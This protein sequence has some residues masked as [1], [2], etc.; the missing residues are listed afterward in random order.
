MRPAHREAVLPYRGGHSGPLFSPNSPASP[1][2]STSSTRSTISIQ[3]LQHIHHLHVTIAVRTSNDRSSST[4]LTISTSN[5]ERVNL[6]RSLRHQDCL[7]RV[8]PPASLLLS[9]RAISPGPTTSADRPLLLCRS[10]LVDGRGSGI[11][12]DHNDSSRSNCHNDSCV[13]PKSKV[14][15]AGL[16]GE[17]TLRDGSGEST[18]RDARDGFS[19]RASLLETASVGGAL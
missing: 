8:R 19:E 16:S 1:D 15:G 4:D 13:Q 17:Y 2:P 3:Q 6:V 5:V 12:C 10:T 18:R 11:L 7:S 14:G 9:T